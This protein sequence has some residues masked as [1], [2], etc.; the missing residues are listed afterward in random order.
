LSSLVDGH[1]IV[2]DGVASLSTVTDGSNDGSIDPTASSSTETGNYFFIY[3][4]YRCIMFG[5]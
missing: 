1:V 5:Q 3:M 4:K 2:I